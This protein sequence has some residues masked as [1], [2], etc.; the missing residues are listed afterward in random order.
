[1]RTLELSLWLVA[2]CWSAWRVAGRVSRRS[3]AAFMVLAGFFSLL[4]AALKTRR[5][6]VKSEATTI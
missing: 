3:T 5:L 2:S 4:L 6:R 1:M